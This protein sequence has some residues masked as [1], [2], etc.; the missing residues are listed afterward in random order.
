VER[1]GRLKL[2]KFTLLVSLSAAV[3]KFKVSAQRRKAKYILNFELFAAD[4]ALQTNKIIIKPRAS[5]SVF[6]IEHEDSQVIAEW[7]AA[8]ETTIK[9]T[10]GISQPA[11]YVS[12]F[13]W[14]K[15]RLR[16]DFIITTYQLQAMVE[17]GD[18]MLF[19]SRKLLAKTWRTLVQHP[20]D[21]VGLLLNI[22]GLTFM[23]E[24]TAGQGV[25]YHALNEV[26]LDEWH[27][28]YSKV[29][30]RRLHCE[31]TAEFEETLMTHLRMWVG[32][33][34]ELSLSKL[35]RSE[36]IALDNQ[37]FFCS[38]LV[39]A[40]YKKLGLLPKG[41]SSCVYWPSSFAVGN[42]LPL[43]DGVCLGEEMEVMV[44]I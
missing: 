13:R 15:V 7:G 12:R 33:P 43:P 38:Q 36:S 14:W 6:S 3:L 5:H 37:D 18:L 2:S 8:L 4:L 20:Y 30:L 19:K 23:V 41:I 24:A 25:T 42:S 11:R 27:N 9:V 39:A 21:H 40:F 22:Q 26:Q 35:T 10:Q 17:S 32:S 16:Q 31:R 28:N 44:N 34:Y 29:V 1:R